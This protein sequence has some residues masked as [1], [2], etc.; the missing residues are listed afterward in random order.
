[1]PGGQAAHSEPLLHE[2]AMVSE[3]LALLSPCPGD[4]ALDLTV[5]PG[6]HALALA[7]AIGP[8]GLLIGID[9]DPA[10][11]RI[12][13]ARLGAEAPCRFQ[14]FHA[15]FGSAARVAREAE[16]GAFDVALADLGVGTHQLLQPA[17]GFSFDSGSR[18]DMR[19]DAAAG[20]SAWD[21]VNTAP[22]G[23]LADIFHRYGEERYSRQVAAAI[24][25]GR[26][27]APIE[28]AAELA[29]LVKAVAA[30]R[31]PRRRTWR[32]HPA[33]RVMMALRIYV[34][35]EIEE[36]GALLEALP[37]LLRKGGRAAILTYHSLEARCVKEAWRRQAKDGLW[38]ILTRSPAKPAADEV[39][40]NPRV[41]SAQL[42]A[43][44]RL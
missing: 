23:E 20:P 8:T 37:G 42:R 22:E 26:V 25:R 21:I 17:R 14:L 7:A 32:I 39:S 5:G 10:A 13:R 41:R 31:T 38:E 19:Y 36:L 30:R 33:T 15:R 3:V 12:A 43:A 40:A 11:L 35:H 34:N 27:E 16:V 4:A 9:A 28:T 18:L 6:G 44:R 24:C 2:P 1:M 29:D